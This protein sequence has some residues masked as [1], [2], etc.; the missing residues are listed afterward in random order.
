MKCPYCSNEMLQ[1][2]INNYDNPVQWFPK[3]INPSRIR[4]KKTSASI[5]L[6]NKFFLF[7]YGYKAEAFYCENCHI[8]IAQT[9]VDKE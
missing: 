4:Y 3:D 6:N 9:E 2:Y 8:V 5:K 1:G 7:K